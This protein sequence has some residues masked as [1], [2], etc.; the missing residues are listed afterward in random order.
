[1]PAL[2][3]PVL[4]AVFESLWSAFFKALPASLVAALKAAFFVALLPALFEAL[5]PSLFDALTPAV[6]A[7]FLQR[8]FASSAFGVG[9]SRPE[10]RV[11]L[12]V[13]FG[14]GVDDRLQDGRVPL[15]VHS[16]GKLGLINTQLPGHLLAH[17]FRQRLERAAE[18]LL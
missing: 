9:D 3:Q 7:T 15:G 6:I 17:P 11:G 18:L 5:P 14:T 16:R 1:L 8:R 4:S 12:P 2:L 10:A 13:G